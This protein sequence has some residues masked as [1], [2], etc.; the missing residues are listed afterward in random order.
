MAVPAVSRRVATIMHNEFSALIERDE[1]WYMAYCLLEIPGA[2]GQGRTKDEAV[3]SLKEA[4]G[5]ILS[6]R[7]DDA[8]RGLPP[9]AVPET[10][11]IG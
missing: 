5:L 6:D 11:T 3:R 9:T 1:D 2:N 10:V 7:R 8:M 4:I